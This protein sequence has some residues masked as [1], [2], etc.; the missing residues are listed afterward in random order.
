MGT[1]AGILGHSGRRLL[2]SVWGY[3]G[4]TDYPMTEAVSTAERRQFADD[5]AAADDAAE[6]DD[7][8]RT[9]LAAFSAAFAG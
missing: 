1:D 7:L 4:E 9:E 5:E 8:R 3:I 2:N 6:T